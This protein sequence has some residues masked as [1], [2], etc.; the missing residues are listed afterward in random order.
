MVFDR[1]SDTDILTRLFYIFSAAAMWLPLLEDFGL[2][3]PYL[4]IRGIIIKDWIIESDLYTLQVLANKVSNFENRL[5]SPQSELAAQTT[6]VIKLKTGD[7][8]P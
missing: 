5:P 1:C 7:F 8:K 4:L 6:V 2:L 3:L